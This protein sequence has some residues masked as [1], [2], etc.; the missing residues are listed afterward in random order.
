MARIT[1]I[2][3][4]YAK[5]WYY[6][7]Q[8]IIHHQILQPIPDESFRALLMAGLRLMQEHGATKWLSDDRLNSILPAE[9]SAWSQDYWL[10]LASQA[11]WKYWAM[12]KPTKAR[13]R[14]N[15]ERLVAYVDEKYDMAIQLF[16]DPELAWQW[17]AQQPNSTG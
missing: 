10:P 13:G 11:G 12:L 17:L 14:I 1:E 9:T 8:G 3:N 7:E 6:P 2:E 5:L 16:T 4:D 15:A